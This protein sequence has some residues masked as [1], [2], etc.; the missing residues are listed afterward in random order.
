MLAPKLRVVPFVPL[1]DS[2]LFGSAL[3]PQWS[4]FYFSIID[5]FF[6]CDIETC[7]SMDMIGWSTMYFQSF[8]T[9]IHVGSTFVFDMQKTLLSLSMGMPTSNNK[10]L[11]DL[12]H[13][14]GRLKF[15]ELLSSLGMIPSIYLINFSHH[16]PLLASYIRGNML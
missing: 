5:Q 7:T 9:C 12:F 16:V 11:F 1:F 13:W 10:F 15:G 6:I 8:Y 4:N 2:V 14:L 3:W